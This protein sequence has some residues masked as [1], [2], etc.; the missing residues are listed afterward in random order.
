ML[1]IVLDLIQ[2]SV[3]SNKVFINLEIFMKQVVIRHKSL[4]VLGIIDHSISI[5]LFK[6]KPK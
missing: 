5:V 1:R 6:S 2:R 4:Y 3:K